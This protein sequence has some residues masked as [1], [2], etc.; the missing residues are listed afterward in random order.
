[1]PVVRQDG[2]V[3]LKPSVGP[4]HDQ[5]CAERLLL[6][7]ARQN[8]RL[9]TRGESQ[10][11]FDRLVGAHRVRD[12]GGLY[13]LGLLASKEPH[14]VHRVAAEVH[15]STAAECG[16]VPDR[17]RVERDRHGE[18]GVERHKM[19]ELARF[20]DPQ[21][22]LAKL[23]GWYRSWNASMSR[24]PVRAATIAISSASA[25]F[26]AIGFSHKTCLPLSSAAIDHLACSEGGNAL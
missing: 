5:R 8:P 17:R 10:L 18:G 16:I 7:H 1:M 19:T 23:S 13:N 3:H 9:D 24:L 11:S 20:S 25:L 26:I 22:V 12:V 21:E 14:P 6:C 15:E 2:V 4:V